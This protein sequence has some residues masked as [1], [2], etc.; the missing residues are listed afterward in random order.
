[1]TRTVY[2]AARRARIEVAGETVRDLLAK[3]DITERNRSRQL[4]RDRFSQEDL[5]AYT[6]A[7][8]VL[9]GE[10]ALG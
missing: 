5:D 10:G 1:M 8:D 2:E 6:L 9:T 7:L 3:Y 4:I